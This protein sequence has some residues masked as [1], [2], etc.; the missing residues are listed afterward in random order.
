MMERDDFIKLCKEVVQSTEEEFRQLFKSI[1]LSV[2]WQLEYQTISDNTRKISQMSFLDLFHKN[3]TYRQLQPTY[4]DVIDQT[5]LSQADIEDKEHDS[6]MH[7]INFSTA[8]NKEPLTIATTRQEL[9]PACDAIFAHP[10]DKRYKK[11]IGA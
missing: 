9:I 8:D 3:E 5:A 10:D 6:A 7:Y 1:A 11:Y 2:D 4:W